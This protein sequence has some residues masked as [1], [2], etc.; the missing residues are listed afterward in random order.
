MTISG[1][2]Q[3]HWAMLVLLLGMGI[4]LYSDIYLERRMIHRIF[5]ANIMMFIYS[6]TCYAETYLGNQ[7]EYTVFRPILSAFNYSLIVFIIVMIVMI[8]FPNQKLY[9]FFPAVMNAVLCF[10]SVPTGIVFTISEDNHFSAEHLD[11]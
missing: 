10:I 2:F 6:I 11:I 9:L 7:T 1:Y 4:V 5:S 8:L 3:E